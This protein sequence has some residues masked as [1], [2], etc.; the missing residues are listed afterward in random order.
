MKKKNFELHRR[1]G[2]LKERKVRPYPI[3]RNRQTGLL[4]QHATSVCTKISTEKKC[5]APRN[6][7]ESCLFVILEYFAYPF[8]VVALSRFRDFLG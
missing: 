6:S 7:Y 5:D 2:I 3:Y 4:L 1:W 8:G